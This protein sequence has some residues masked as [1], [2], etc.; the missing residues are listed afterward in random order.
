MCKYEMGYNTL[1]RIGEIASLRRH[2]F[3]VDRASTGKGYVI[4]S[5]LKLYLMSFSAHKAYGPKGIGDLV[6]QTT[7]RVD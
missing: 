6:Y 3:H 7:T 1:L 4:L 2:I 5:N